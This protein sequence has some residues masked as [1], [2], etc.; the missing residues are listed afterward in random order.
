M[1][2]SGQST[3]N[4]FFLAALQGAWLEIPTSLP[5]HE[6]AIHASKPSRHTQQ[7]QILALHQQL[8]AR[9]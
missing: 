2:G 5:T 7:S 3:F 8:P 4:G 6:A 9:T 1:L